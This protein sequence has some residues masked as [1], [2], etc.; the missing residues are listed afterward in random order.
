MLERHGSVIEAE[1]VRCGAIND[2][3]DRSAPVPGTKSPMLDRLESGVGLSVESDATSE[4]A[5]DPYRGV[6]T[7]S[8]GSVRV[9]WSPRGVVFGM[10]GLTVLLAPV[11]WL[12]SPLLVLPFAAL[13]LIA[14]AS[15]ATDSP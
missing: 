5:L 2:L 11:V 10:A 12:V 7:R 1:C 14:A 6:A 8:A 13:A 15:A 4:G 3:D 9:S